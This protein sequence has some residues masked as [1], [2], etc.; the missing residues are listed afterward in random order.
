MSTELVAK[1]SVEL[2]YLP[3]D[4]PLGHF[5]DLEMLLIYIH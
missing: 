3:Q 4:L 1:L 5:N 2:H